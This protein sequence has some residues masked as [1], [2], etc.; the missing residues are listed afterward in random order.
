MSDFGRKIAAELPKMRAAAESLMLDTVLV[1]RV[2]GESTLDPETDER[3]DPPR[4]TVYG[5]DIAPHFGKRRVQVA[6]VLAGSTESSS[7][8]RAG[9]VQEAT[10]QLPVTGS[11]GVAIG[12]VAE[13]LT[14]VSDDALV[15]RFLTVTALHAKSQA[16]ARRLRVTE[17]TG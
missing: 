15:G 14:C 10:L 11:E 3:I 2:T 4:V 17:V 1:T 7:G 13:I 9:T 12:H 5:P 16:T 8:E 6:S